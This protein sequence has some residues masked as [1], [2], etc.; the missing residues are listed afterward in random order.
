MRLAD[1]LEQIEALIHRYVEL[2]DSALAM[3]IAVWIANTYTFECFDYCGYLHI[4]SATPG[5]G[6]TT[7]LKVLR[8]LATGKPP[9]LTAPTAAV[10]FRTQKDVKVL[11]IDEAERLRDHDKENFGTLLAVLNAGIEKD[12]QVIRLK[13][14]RRDDYDPRAFPV[15]GP[16][17]L[18]GLE[19]LAATLESRCFHVQMQRAVTRVDRFR[20]RKVEQAAKPIRDHLKQWATG[21]RESLKAVYDKI[22]QTERSIP[23]LKGYDDRLQDL[24][25]PLMV[26]AS[27]ADAERPEG[28]LIAPRLIEGIKA[29]SGDRSPTGKERDIVAFLHGARLLLDGQDRAFVTARDLLT[30]CQ[31]TPGLSGL[32]DAQSL[33]VFLK[34]FGLASR[35]NGT[36]RGYELRREWV[37]DLS[38][39]YS[40][41]AETPRTPDTSDG[42]TGG[43]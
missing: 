40:P 1:E 38:K 42:S 28:P 4:Q 24:A 20:S 12:G 30:T 35:S 18:A 43:I 3:L 17:G 9:I 37:D 2:S 16:K 21:Q 26:L 11:F 36:C 6:K 33:A 39:R 27:V 31:E 5:C 7:L 14:N 15:F 8:H 29:A 25:E 23:E 32:E 13:K 22:V 19:D 41:R 34:L 10:V